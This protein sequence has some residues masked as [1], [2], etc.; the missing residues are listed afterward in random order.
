MEIAFS[1]LSLGGKDRDKSHP[2]S[3]GTLEKAFYLYN[4]C[5]LQPEFWRKMTDGDL[6]TFGI[7]VL[8]LQYP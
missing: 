6:A 8:I 1:D 7:L 5:E 4:K 3:A 2:A